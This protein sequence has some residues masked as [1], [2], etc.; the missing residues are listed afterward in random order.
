MKMDRRSPLCNFQKNPSRCRYT[1]HNRFASMY[2]VR[3]NHGE[4]FY[5]LKIPLRF[6][7]CGYTINAETK[8]PTEIPMAVWIIP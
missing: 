3:Q 4:S 5:K 1:M 7:P 6:F 2:N 8:R